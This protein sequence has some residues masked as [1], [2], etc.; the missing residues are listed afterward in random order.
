M[1]YLLTTIVIISSSFCSYYA[2]GDT[3]IASHQNEAFDVCYGEYPNNQLSLSHFNGKISIFGLSTTWWPTTCT[4]SLEALIDTLGNDNRINIFESLDDINQPYSCTQ[5]GDLGQEGIPIIA[6]TN[7]QFYEWFSIHGYRGVPVVL[8]HNMVFRY[9]GYDPGVNGVLDIVN[10]I[11]TEIGLMGDLDSD[12]IIN[13][14]DIILTVNLVLSSE[15]NSL[16]D[17]NLDSNVDVL[18]IIQILNIILN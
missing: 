4:F 18:D 9:I 13:I 2:I 12:G 14:Q 10:Q 15:Y 17:L 6:E 7:N 11:L 1:K 5:W 8:D 16:A 3:V